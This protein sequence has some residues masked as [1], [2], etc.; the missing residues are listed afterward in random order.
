VFPRNVNAAGR[1]VWKNSKITGF[2][3]IAVMLMLF[4]QTLLKFL[5][6]SPGREEQI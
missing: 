3:S 6:L 2:S 5:V 4:L 1:V